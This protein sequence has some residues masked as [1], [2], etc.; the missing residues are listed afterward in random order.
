M[1]SNGA[2]A[3]VPPFPLGYRVSG[4]L[5][6]VASLPSQHGIGDLGSSAFSWVDRLHFAEPW[7]I[8]QNHCGRTGIIS[9]RIR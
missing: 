8:Q 7:S 5:L 4:L 2:A 9:F 3:T 1:N 6:H